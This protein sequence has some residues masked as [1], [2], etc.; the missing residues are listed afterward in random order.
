[1]VKLKLVFCRPTFT[2]ELLNVLRWKKLS[3]SS[4]LSDNVNLF[5]AKVVRFNEA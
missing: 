5:K 2:N 1:M 3:L 4:T